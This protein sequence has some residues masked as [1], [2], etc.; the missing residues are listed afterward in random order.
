MV[1][2]NQRPSTDQRD[3]RSPPTWSSMSDRK[4]RCFGTSLFKVEGSFR[5]ALRTA[6]HQPRV[7]PRCGACMDTAHWSSAELILHGCVGFK[8]DRNHRCPWYCPLPSQSSVRAVPPCA[9]QLLLAAS[10]PFASATHTAFRCRWRAGGVTAAPEPTARVHHPYMAWQ[11][12]RLQFWPSSPSL[13]QASPM[14][15]SYRR[16]LAAHMLG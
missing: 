6:M 13:T 8:H 4:R 10:L 15:K 3:S 7:M 16:V 1:H 2:V 9:R 5:P 14:R 12:L 11:R